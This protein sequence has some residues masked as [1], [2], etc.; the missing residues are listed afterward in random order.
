MAVFLSFVLPF[1]FLG[2]VVPKIP[3]TSNFSWNNLLQ[4]ETEGGVD[5][6]ET[7]VEKNGWKAQ[8]LFHPDRI[9]IMEGETIEFGAI[10]SPTKNAKYSGKIRIK[11]AMVGGE[12]EISLGDVRTIKVTSDK[13]LD[14]N[15]ATLDCPGIGQ[16]WLQ[17]I[18]TLPDGNSIRLRR[19]IVIIDRESQTKFTIY[20][21][22]APVLSDKPWRRGADIAAEAGINLMLFN[23]IDDWNGEAGKRAEE[24]LDWFACFGIDWID[25][26]STIDWTLIHAPIATGM[27]DAYHDPDVRAFCRQLTQCVA[28]WGRKLPSFL[29]ISLMDEPAARSFWG[30]NADVFRERFL[31]YDPLAEPLRF[32]ADYHRFN[33]WSMGDLFRDCREAAMKVDKRLKICVEGHNNF[34]TGS[35]IY[36]PLNVS[37]LDLNTTHHYY[38]DYGWG[39]F[40][41]LLGCEMAQVGLRHMPLWMMGGFGPLKRHQYEAQVGQAIARGAKAFGYF[42]LA[43]P[44]RFL[45]MVG[46]IKPINL[47]LRRIGTIFQNLKRKRSEVAVLF[48]VSNAAFFAKHPPVRFDA[49]KD[50]QALVKALSEALKMLKGATEMD[51]KHGVVMHEPDE[52]TDYVGACMAAFMALNF[53]GY[54]AEFIVEEE[55]TPQWLSGKKV[56][57]APQIVY[58][59]KASMDALYQ[60]VKSGGIVLTDSETRLHSEI[61]QKLPVSIVSSLPER[62]GFE[63]RKDEQEAKFEEIRKILG[64]YLGKYVKPRLEGIPKGI[65]YGYFDGG[66]ARYL[67]IANV[68]WKRNEQGKRELAPFKGEITARFLRPGLRIQIGK[69]IVG[70]GGETQR[71]MLSL[72]E[73]K[74]AIYA[75]VPETIE[76]VSVNVPKKVVQGRRQNFAVTLI[77][78]KGKSLPI[79]APLEVQI[80]VG[81][82]KPLTYFRA[83]DEN[84]KFNGTFIVPLESAAKRVQIKV[85]ELLTNKSTTLSV[86][87]NSSKAFI[88]SEELPMVIISDRDAIRQFFATFSEIK[89]ISPPELNDYAATL[90]KELSELFRYS[91]KISIDTPENARKLEKFPPSVDPE[92]HRKRNPNAQVH[93][94]FNPTQLEIGTPAILIGDERNNEL[95]R[96]LIHANLLPRR[97]N[98]E[99]Y[100]LRALLQYAW[101]PFDPDKDVIILYAR[102]QEALRTGVEA[103]VKL[104][105]MAKTKRR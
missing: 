45:E 98:N 53:S 86:E 97:M 65:I 18:I 6:S 52:R 22:A 10:I 7:V 2:A 103:I 14:A 5:L 71:W 90:A 102:T 84:G 56:L 37:H 17:C 88:N 59:P 61:W 92:F 34:W 9:G 89:L 69:G 51:V 12:R 83:T 44:K 26:P 8:I 87:I 63:E 1:F 64:E 4:F 80:Q 54:D 82:A 42:E 31:I 68:S 50:P 93:P 28:Q 96:D 104:A 29:G 21:C 47:E 76:K 32:Y 66:M 24:T 30:N 36:A 70:K 46:E 62:V 43:E 13:V 19:P 91:H 99:L 57:I 23:A 40:A 41:T 35:G 78:S 15:S 77:G 74:F 101:S 3:N 81:N 60:F 85:T 38:G 55:L 73:G 75:F 100:S 105:K 20:A 79:V 27:W 33:C 67:V 72:P 94:H 49:Y 48:S 58:L 11:W 25:F 95:I 39:A 16:F